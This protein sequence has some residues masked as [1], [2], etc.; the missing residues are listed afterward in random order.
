MRRGNEKKK[1]RKKERGAGKV[2]L[3]VHTR[4]CAQDDN[5]G[6]PV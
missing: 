5:S 3:T 4:N 2:A 1:E 6:K